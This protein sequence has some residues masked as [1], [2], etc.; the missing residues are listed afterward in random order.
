MGAAASL[1]GPGSKPGQAMECERAHASWEIPLLV[2]SPG[3]GYERH[4]AGP[5]WDG[6]EYGVKGTG[7]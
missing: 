3:P 7:R 5:V 6:Q 4:L 1:F 2:F